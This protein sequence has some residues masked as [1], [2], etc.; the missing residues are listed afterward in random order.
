[1]HKKF[2]SVLF[3]LVSSFFVLVSIFSLLVK[4]PVMPRAAVYAAATAEDTFL[5]LPLIRRD[6]LPPVINTFTA[7]VAV[8]DPGETIILSWETAHA[9]TVSLYH[10]LPTGQFGTF[11]TVSPT[12]SMTYTI[13]SSTRNFERFMLYA[14]NDTHP[15][16]SADV[17]IILNCPYPW[18]FAPAPDICA[19]DAAPDTG[20]AEQQF[21][22]GFMIWVESENRIYV[23]YDDDIY[24]PK[25]AA[26]NDE[27]QVGDPI[28]DPN[29][30]PPPGYYQ[31]VRGFGL[32]WRE[33]PDVRDRLGWAVAPEAGFV[34]AVQRTSY[35]KYN[36]TYI[37]A[38]DGNI[39]HLLAERS[40]WEKFTPE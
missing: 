3:S 36:H 39:W 26:F 21:E 27:W 32:V 37:R 22:H 7:N 23:L 33:Q 30:T 4:S 24:S 38:L 5:Y 28:D 25:W 19:Q 9:T 8:T 6:E 35:A 13:P 34:T 20:G 15:Y 17:T 16:T 11:W 10:L 40:G 2:V 12:G 1:M 18:F 14:D 31:P 29:I